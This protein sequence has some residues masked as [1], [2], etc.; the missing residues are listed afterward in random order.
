MNT[1]NCTRCGLQFTKPKKISIT[2]WAGRQ[3]CSHSCAA[4][5]HDID[6]KQLTEMYLND[7][8]SS[9]EI[10]AKFGIS[11]VHVIR[12]L[13]SAGVER[14]PRSENKSLALSRPEVREKMRLSAEGR[15][16][17]ETAKSKLR[18]I[19]GS[20]NANW[21]GGM[22]ITK[23]GYIAFTPSPEN[24]DKAGKLLHV[25]VAEWLYQ[26]KLKPGEHVHHI[27]GNKLNNNPENLCI[28]SASE[29][30]NIHNLGDKG[31]G[32]RLKSM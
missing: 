2:Q 29:H 32:Q 30:A 12:I 19:T 17:S 7:K 3:F 4:K 6:V 25:I 14:R 10:G 28:L 31:N 5:K 11:P 18:L 24:G 8:L 21:L 13:I 16:L 9:N 1:K 26:R 23:Q 22:T 27:D 20:K 15:R